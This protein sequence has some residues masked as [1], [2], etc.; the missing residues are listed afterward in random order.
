MGQAPSTLD[1]MTAECQ[2]AHTLLTQRA[3]SQQRSSSSSPLQRCPRD[4]LS[5]VC[6][7][8]GALELVAAVRTCRDLHAASELNTAQPTHL[9]Q[10]TDERLMSDSTWTGHSR[11]ALFD[12]P[13]ITSD[14]CVARI[15]PTH[16]ESSVPLRRPRVDAWRLAASLQSHVWR[17]SHEVR[18]SG[19]RRVSPNTE[20]REE[21]LIAAVVALPKLRVLDLQWNDPRDSPRMFELLAPKLQRLELGGWRAPLNSVGLGT[22]TQLRVLHVSLRM[23]EDP[24]VMLGTMHQLEFLSYGCNVLTPFSPVVREAYPGVDN[25]MQTLARV[26]RELAVHHALRGGRF[27]GAMAGFIDALV[28]PPSDA[29]NNLPL[30][31]LRLL[32]L[33]R[34]GEGWDVHRRTLLL[35]QLRSLHSQVPPSMLLAE[36]Q[37]PRQMAPEA[38]Q[39]LPEHIARAALGRL[40]ILSVDN[41]A[42]GGNRVADSWLP[43]LACC[44]SLKAL[45]APV[46][47]AL[48]EGVCNALTSS[49]SQ[50]HHRQPCPP[51]ERMFLLSP[52]SARDDAGSALHAPALYS[53][54]SVPGSFERLAVED[55]S[56][57][58]PLLQLQ[59]LKQLHVALIRREQFEWDEQ[60]H[61]AMYSALAQLPLFESL[62]YFKHSSDWKH[63]VKQPWALRFNPTM[64]RAMGS[65]RSWTSVHALEGQRAEVAKNNDELRSLSAEECRALRHLCVHTPGV[66]RHTHRWMQI[67]PIDSTQPESGFHW[68]LTVDTGFAA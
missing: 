43:A 39:P 62:H 29:N 8:L 12:P 19:L 38:L 2:Q 52:S 35:P 5:G 54:G 67:R 42:I 60:A 22:L 31:P 1:A 25:F 27:T 48:L 10:L 59:S 65:T 17:H 16:A 40:E 7:C 6:A 46:P 23:P 18:I 57:W 24:E 55:P 3:Q 4:L 13:R 68:I 44:F 34:L 49:S 26:I 45:I 51:L 9:T 66:V 64:L 11:F 14:R 63:A 61:T 58:R 20:D 15:L 30:P 50:E 47:H 33:G 36:Q 56:R 21:D 32:I 41:D 53:A 37:P 28:A